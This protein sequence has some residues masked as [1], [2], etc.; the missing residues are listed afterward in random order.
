MEIVEI[1]SKDRL[2]CEFREISK[3]DGE[4]LGE[5]F[6]ELSDETRSRFAPHPLTTEYADKL[7]LNLSDDTAERFVL[8]FQG[9]IVG[10][11]IL[12]NE[13]SSHEQKRYQPFGINLES[14]K[15]VLFAPCI[16][17]EFQNKG[18]AS[19]VMSILIEHA[20]EKQVRSIVLLGGTQETNT[21]ARAFYKKFGFKEFGGYQT[22][23][24]NIDMR[25]ELL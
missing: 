12:D 11:F 18:L 16:A 24:Y 3:N 7:C 20:K 4:T 10:Y 17:D 23:I 14:K 21:L 1:L 9:N 15:D 19:N 13:M 5:F 2:R 25:L 22:E 8:Y 6:S